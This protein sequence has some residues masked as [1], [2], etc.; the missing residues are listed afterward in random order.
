MKEGKFM[1]T[2]WKAGSDLPKIM[3]IPQVDGAEIQ[4]IHEHNKS[5]DGYGFTHG[6]SIARHRGKL[7][8]AWAANKGQE[9]TQAEVVCGS[10][11]QDGKWSAAEEWLSY[12]TEA[13]S[14][15]VLL[16]HDGVLWGFFPHFLGLRENL[17]THIYRLDDDT[18]KFIETGLFPEAP[19]WP[20]TE[21]QRLDNGSYL[22]AGCWVCGGLDMTFNPPA[23][24]ISEGD[25]LER[26]RVVRIPKP[27]NLVIWGESTPIIRGSEILIICRSCFERQV[28]FVSRSKDWGETWSELEESNLPMCESK[29][30]SGVLSDGRGYLVASCSK[31]GGCGRYPLT[32]ALS[33]PGKMCFDR[34]LTVRGHDLNL[35][36]PLEEKE[37]M[38]LH[39]PY[40][41]ELDKK[42][43]IVYSRA[44]CKYNF[45]ANDVNSIELAIVPLKSLQG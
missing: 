2:L 24:A 36:R 14:H 7:Y 35:D 32:I 37:L 34:V 25:N 6:A 8:A 15:G 44:I 3:D 16:E 29:P 17:R 19:F 41:V 39:Y 10:V 21:P 27:E 28:A 45:P 22:M 4:V 23:V 11:F 43:Y 18:G 12:D 33:A 9:N 30:Y 5:A 38:V 13:V 40:A 31:D 1:Y 26:W 42:L 20:L